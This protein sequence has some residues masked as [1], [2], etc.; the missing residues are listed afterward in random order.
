MPENKEQGRVSFGPQSWV[1]PMPVLVVGTYD[2]E[3][4]PDAMTAAWGGVHDTNQIGMCL[5]AGHRTVKNLLAAK[6]N[7]DAYFSVSPAVAG[8]AAAA[9]AVGMVSADKNPDKCARAGLTPV[10]CGSIPAPRFAELPLTL[11][12]RL[13]S[14]DPST[15][16]LVGDILNVTADEAVLGENGKPDFAKLSPLVFD[17]ANASYYRV[18]GKEDDAF[19][20]LI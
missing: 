4:R 10:R 2:P 6:E 16:A 12:C 17:P 8:T 1:Y 19:V 20:H 5:S 15:G 13:V 3:G 14:Y 18:G 7:G 9:D 11:E